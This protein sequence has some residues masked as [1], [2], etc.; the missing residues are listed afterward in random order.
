M[1][2]HADSHHSYDAAQSVSTTKTVFNDGSLVHI[3]PE[4]RCAW[5]DHEPLCSTGQ[6]SDIDTQPVEEGDGDVGWGFCLL[7][8]FMGRFSIWCL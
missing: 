1:S 2:P 3:D 4:V 8:I 6:D 7:P 5:C